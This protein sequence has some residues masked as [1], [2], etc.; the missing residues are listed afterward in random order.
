MGQSNISD[1]NTECR[2]GLVPPVKCDS[3]IWDV[4]YLDIYNNAV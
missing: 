3:L 1:V 4:V 2:P